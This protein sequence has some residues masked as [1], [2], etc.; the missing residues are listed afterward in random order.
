MSQELGSGMPVGHRIVHRV[1]KK[2]IERRTRAR[3]SE[4]KRVRNEGCKNE[5]D[6][7]IKQHRVRATPFPFSSQEA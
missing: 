4:K 6:K 1:S 7:M 3:D 2:P 5:K